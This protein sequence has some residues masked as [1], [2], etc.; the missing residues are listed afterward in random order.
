[1]E[2]L[3]S[4][5]KK[6]SK[7]LFNHLFNESDRVVIQIYKNRFTIFD[8]SIRLADDVDDFEVQYITGGK[9]KFTFNN[10]T[11]FTLELV[12]NSSQIK[13][14]LSIKFRTSFDNI[15]ELYGITRAGV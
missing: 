4:N 5:P 1:M 13:E 3:T 14:N 6:Y 11:I 12:L 9:L 15:Y 10:G 8:F 7:F 2:T